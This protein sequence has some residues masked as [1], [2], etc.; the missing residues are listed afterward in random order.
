MLKEPATLLNLLL[1]QALSRKVEDQVLNALRP[2]CLSLYIGLLCSLK[3][4]HIDELLELQDHT[5]KGG[6]TV[7]WTS[8][9]RSMIVRGC[10]AIL[11]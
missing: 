11:L 8:V 10:F 6:Q 2:E 4:S 3:L 7:L 9:M 5:L 1:Q